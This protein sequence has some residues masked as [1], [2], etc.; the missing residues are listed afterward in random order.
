MGEGEAGRQAYFKQS[1]W[2]GRRNA[3]TYT[4]I[5]TRMHRN[6]TLCVFVWVCVFEEE[7]TIHLIKV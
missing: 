2:S 1:K 7:K 5:H 4:N 3:Q 6:L